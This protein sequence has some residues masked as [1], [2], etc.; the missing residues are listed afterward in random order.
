MEKRTGAKKAQDT[1]AKPSAQHTV[2]EALGKV[3]IDQE[4][5]IFQKIEK[6]QAKINAEA[7]ISQELSNVT[8]ELYLHLPGKLL[9]KSEIKFK[10]RMKDIESA[11]EISY[12]LTAL[13]HHKRAQADFKAGR[14]EAAL[15]ECVASESSIGGATALSSYEQI[16][17]ARARVRA[18]ASH[19]DTR[20]IKNKVIAYWKKKISP[21]LS[22]PKAASE[23]CGQSIFRKKNGEDISYKFLEA[24]VREAKKA[25]K[26]QKKT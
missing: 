24:C 19:A 18:S 9:E 25:A 23:M 13:N 7:D 26:M 16:S 1:S 5:R 6:A 12:W 2:L 3:I 20:A 8:Y 17:S 15:K 10:G 21:T 4:T 14:Y 11:A 22:A